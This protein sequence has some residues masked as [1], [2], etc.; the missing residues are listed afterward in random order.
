[1]GN[2]R[3]LEWYR[4]QSYRAPYARRRSEAGAKRDKKRDATVVV[5]LLGPPVLLLV[6]VAVGI[7]VEVVVGVLSLK[8]ALYDVLQRMAC[9][10][11]TIREGHPPLG[12]KLRPCLGD[13]LLSDVVKDI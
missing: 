11:F 2:S 7:M 6:L 12:K 10:P 9:F 8:E 13:S 4:S 1:M 3:T 5:A